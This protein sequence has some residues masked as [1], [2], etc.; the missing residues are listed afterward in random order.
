MRIVFILIL[1]VLLTSCS[2]RNPDPIKSSDV[3]AIPASR[4]SVISESAEILATNLTVPWE[5][6]KVGNQYISS[7]AEGKFSHF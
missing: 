7:R 3:E 1:A 4:D 6:V 2:D 5:I